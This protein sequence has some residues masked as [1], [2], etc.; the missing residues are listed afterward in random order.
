MVLFGLGFQSFNHIYL[1]LYVYFVLFWSLKCLCE[2]RVPLNLWIGKGI[3]DYSLLSLSLSLSLYLYWRRKWW[4]LFPYLLWLMKLLSCLM[5]F[6]FAFV[7]GLLK[8]H[9]AFHIAWARRC[10]LFI[11]FLYFSIFRYGPLSHSISLFFYLCF[12]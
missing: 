2:F 10:T 8:K 4:Y 1:F 5:I 12:P 3:M 6:L 9:I 7:L 11:R